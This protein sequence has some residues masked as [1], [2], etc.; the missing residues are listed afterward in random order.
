MA[1][2]FLSCTAAVMLDS[3]LRSEANL[4]KRTKVK[5]LSPFSGTHLRQ[6]AYSTSL[7]GG[8]SESAAGCTPLLSRSSVTDCKSTFRKAH[9]RSWSRT[10][11]EFRFS[12]SMP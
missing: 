4:T 2:Y 3:F 12:A 11:V 7:R 8:S 6:A 1:D 5:A 10:L 9:S